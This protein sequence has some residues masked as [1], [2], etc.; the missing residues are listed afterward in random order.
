[1]LPFLTCTD[2]ATLA[3]DISEVE[4]TLVPTLINVFR[5][6]GFKGMIS[7]YVFILKVLML[8]E[9]TSGMDPSARRFTWDLLQ[10]YRGGRTILL[11][12]HFMDEA[13]VLG[14]RIA[15]MAEGKVQCC[16]SSLFLKNHYGVGYHIVMVKQPDCKVKRITELVKQFVPLAE[17]ESNAGEYRNSLDK[18][19]RSMILL[20]VTLIIC[21]S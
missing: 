1:M 11:T 14:D 9:P 2:L 4:K 7:W 5:L 16:G 18:Y 20:Y 17:L 21:Y 12:T 15:I 10:R 6:T 3:R 13:D 8:D 19:G